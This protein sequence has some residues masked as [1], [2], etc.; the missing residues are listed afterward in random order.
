MPYLQQLRQQRPSHKHTPW[1]FVPNCHATTRTATVIGGGIAGITTAYML[2]REQWKVNLIERTEQIAS[3]A[4]GNNAAILMPLISHK[5][6]SLG[7]FYCKGYIATLKLLYQLE[8]PSW[9][10]CG[11]ID[12]GPRH[13]DKMIK[14]ICIPNHLIQIRNFL[15]KRGFF[16]KEGGYVNTPALCRY[17]LDKAADNICI[18]TE[19]DAIHIEPR[20]HQWQVMTT[21]SNT[22]MSD[23]VVIANSYDALKFKQTS[24]LPIEKVRGQIT[25]LPQQEINLPHVI[26]SQGYMTPA[27]DGYHT[28]GATYNRDNDISVK[29]EDHRENLLPFASLFSWPMETFNFDTMKGRVAFR[30][31]TPD[32]RAIVG[33]VPIYDAFSSD[34][35]GIIHG[36]RY[37]ANDISSAYYPG[38]YINTAHGSRGLTS[39]ILSAI[40]L[41]SMIN[42]KS[43]SD[44]ELMHLLLPT[45]FIIRELKKAIRKVSSSSSIMPGRG[46]LPDNTAQDKAV[47]P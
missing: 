34:Y 43:Y 7:Q 38:L 27:Q 8:F 11:V 42:N 2:A 36:H 17:L 19:H 45:R 33:P 1:F 3:Q 16:F 13:T 28:I 18:I 23:V 40:Y 46:S 39:C 24:W 20:N 12:L 6:D 32:R 44:P 15:G 29:T 31:S 37:G 14:D 21:S 41:E 35:K 30:A 22:F 9:N 4:S 5:E 10:Q 47:F 25:L 26:C